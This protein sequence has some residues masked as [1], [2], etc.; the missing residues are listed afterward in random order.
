MEEERAS[1]AALLIMVG[2]P[3]PEDKFSPYLAVSVEGAA[4]GRRHA[5]LYA[6]VDR[7]YGSFLAFLRSQPSRFLVTE[8][9]KSFRPLLPAGG[10][11]MVLRSLVEMQGVRWNGSA[12]TPQQIADALPKVALDRL[13]EL[14]GSLERWVEHAWAAEI[15]QIENEAWLREEMVDSYVLRS[16]AKR[17]Q[18]GVLTEA[19]AL[20]EM[21]RWMK[22]NWEGPVVS[23][24]RK[25]VIDLLRAE[26][27][28]SLAAEEMQAVARLSEALKLSPEE[29][30]VA[31][32]DHFGDERETEAFLLGVQGDDKGGA[33]WYCPSC[34]RG[35]A[36]DVLECRACLEA[37]EPS[38][39]K[40][41]LTVGV[42]LNQIV[43]AQFCPHDL[44]MGQC[45]QCS[46]A[47]SSVKPAP[48]RAPAV[49]SPPLSQKDLEYLWIYAS[50][51]LV[52]AR[53]LPISLVIER[54]CLDHAKG[55]PVLSAQVR[56]QDQPAKLFHSAPD[57]WFY[58][59]RGSSQIALSHHRPESDPLSIFARAA[60]AIMEFEGVDR[61]AMDKILQ[62]KPQLA[63]VI[64][65][66]AGKFGAVIDRGKGMGLFSLNEQRGRAPQVILSKLTPDITLPR[67]LFSLFVAQ[68]LKSPARSIWDEYLSEFPNIG[69]KTL[70]GMIRDCFGE[71]LWVAADGSFRGN[72]NQALGIELISKI[73]DSASKE[74]SAGSV[75]ELLQQKPLLHQAVLR[76]FKNDEK[77]AH[78]AL[79]ISLAPPVKAETVPQV[80][81]VAAPPVSPPLKK[82]TSPRP[83]VS[84]SESQVDWV[85]AQI[86][87][88]FKFKA[89]PN[90]VCIYLDVQKCVGFGFADN[91]RVEYA[92]HI[93]DQ[94][95]VARLQGV[96][97]L[98]LH[99]VHVFPGGS[100]ATVSIVHPI[101]CPPRVVQVLEAT[102]CCL[103]NESESSIGVLRALSLQMAAQRRMCCVVDTSGRIFGA[104]QDHAPRRM[105]PASCANR[106][107]SDLIRE[108]ANHADFI[109]VDQ[110]D[111][112]DECLKAF[113]QL[114][115][116]K[117]LAA[118]VDSNVRVFR[119]VARLTDEVEILE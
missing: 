6:D 39:M 22:R 43:A 114:S 70:D 96:S 57:Q 30:T 31:Y 74:C 103:L 105:G 93:V 102:R 50:A 8:D 14:F 79:K 97:F 51:L 91:F 55:W 84:Q 46:Q 19:D 80:E 76:Q 110:L 67:G 9:G 89:P 82:V 85:L 119:R 29:V 27:E 26:A 60:A 25:V 37:A 13:L 64:R 78:A 104:L 49:S 68:R 32:L 107:V 52:G 41:E 63:Q 21:E 73:L 71:D 15:D 4:F 72:V 17:V 92:E 47:T 90:A 86:L 61:L 53:S 95:T 24:W 34:G 101:D 5:A 7:I 54:F 113:G 87:G 16:C 48:S 33:H 75:G 38:E 12:P 1:F 28:T 35:Y 36:S 20:G 69:P 115:M 18:M 62:G 108:A 44:P 109:V 23:S 65:T 42:D 77:A 58:L 59:P 117:H 56:G 94:A 10:H 98:G 100:G 112:I 3:V 83:D 81:Q 118:C 11:A 2:C 66:A 106:S 88:K 45:A 40:P 111:N 99:R 116:R